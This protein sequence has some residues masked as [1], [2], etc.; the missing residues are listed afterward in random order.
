MSIYDT[1]LQCKRCGR[2]DIF[3]KDEAEKFVCCKGHP[4]V[5][6][7]EGYYDGWWE[8][9]DDYPDAREDW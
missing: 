2:P 3:T 4:M 5:I 8:M 9:V 1:Y 6:S 7:S